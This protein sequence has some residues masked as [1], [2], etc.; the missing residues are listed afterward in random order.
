MMAI[1]C[2]NALNGEYVV[3]ESD[4]SNYVLNIATES[5]FSQEYLLLI[6]AE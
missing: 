5:G 2:G 6:D 3:E 1:L 4:E